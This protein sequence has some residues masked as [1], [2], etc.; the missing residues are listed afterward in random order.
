M[1]NAATKSN[2][3]LGAADVD[4]DLELEVDLKDR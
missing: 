1:S 3:A 4:V 2:A